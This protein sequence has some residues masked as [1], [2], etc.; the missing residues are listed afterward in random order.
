MTFAD[1]LPPP[2]LTP[3]CEVL[4]GMGERFALSGTPLGE[5]AVSEVNTLRISGRRLNASL[6]GKAAADWLIVAP[7]R[8]F[9]MLDVRFTVRTDDDALIFVQYNGRLRFS[10]TG[11]HR[12][13]VA[14]RFETGDPRYGWLNSLQAIGTGVFDPAARQL[15]YAFYEVA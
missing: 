13:V 1:S 5:R 8:S 2:T 3:I 6:A 14:P 11:P 7:D 15:R 12:A 9:A 4:A 10:A